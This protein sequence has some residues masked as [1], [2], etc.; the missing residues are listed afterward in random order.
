MSQTIREAMLEDLIERHIVGI[1]AGLKTAFA[2][3]LLEER[4]KIYAELIHDYRLWNGW[5]L[6]EGDPARRI[7]EDL[8]RRRNNLT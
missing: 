3:V 5:S 4:R 7:I 2:R 6:V 1:T 8:E